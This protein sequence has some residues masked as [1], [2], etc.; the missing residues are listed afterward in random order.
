MAARELAPGD[1]K[2]D[3]LLLEVADDVRNPVVVSVEISSGV[4]IVLGMV[5][6]VGLEFI[7]ETYLATVVSLQRIQDK[8]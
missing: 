6:D 1:A 5:D 3:E 8:C 7:R 2:K 4:N